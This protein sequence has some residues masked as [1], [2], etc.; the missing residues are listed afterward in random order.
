MV[1]EAIM[2]AFKAYNWAG[3]IRELKN[4]IESAMN[5]VSDEHV[6][7]TEH[8]PSHV[9]EVLMK[10]EKYIPVEAVEVMDLNVHLEGIEK[11]MIYK[12]LERADQNVSLAASMLKISR[13]NLQYK[14]KK[15]FESEG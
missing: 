8:L 14:I 1:S 5:L 7:G 13:Q 15:Y 6:I 9:L 11:A 2:E 3:N 4:F 12:A 10:K